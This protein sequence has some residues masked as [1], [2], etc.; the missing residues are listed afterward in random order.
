MYDARGR[1]LKRFS[2]TLG[3]RPKNVGVTPT[4]AVGGCSSVVDVMFAYLPRASTIS[5]WQ[6]QDDIY[7]DSDHRY[8]QFTL[9]SASIVT[10][11]HSPLD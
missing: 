6:V 7:S 10:S 9:S 4:F 1:I 11:R 3:L 5:G 8:I 2:A